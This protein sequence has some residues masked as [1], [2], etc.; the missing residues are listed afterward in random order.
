[1]ALRYAAMLYVHV[2][3]TAPV[4]CRMLPPPYAFL[5]LVDLMPPLM[6]PPLLRH[7]TLYAVAVLPPPMSMPAIIYAVRH[8]TDITMEYAAA[9]AA[10]RQ[11]HA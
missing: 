9:D 5:P 11:C 10:I 4:V 6:M 2:S 7:D 1:M 3:A 8:V